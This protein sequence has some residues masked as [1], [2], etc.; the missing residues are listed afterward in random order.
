MNKKH[1]NTVIFEGDLDHTLL[2]ELVNHSYELVA[3]KLTKKT[4][5]ELKNL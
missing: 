4:K 5:E 3:S 1:W 2:C